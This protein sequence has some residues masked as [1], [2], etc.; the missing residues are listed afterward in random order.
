MEKIIVDKK[1]FVFTEEQL[2]DTEYTLKNA[3]DGDV[4]SAHFWNKKEQHGGGFS[5]LFHFFR[6][7]PA[8]SNL[9]RIE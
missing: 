9:I 4:I 3:K 2:K 8:P 7:N 1:G 5:F 6:K